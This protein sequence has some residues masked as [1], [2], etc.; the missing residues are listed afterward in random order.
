MRKVCGRAPG[1]FAIGL[2]MADGNRASGYEF[3]TGL[4]RR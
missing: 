4:S 3:S 1:I 2:G